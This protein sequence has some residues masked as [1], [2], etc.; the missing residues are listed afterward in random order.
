M[1][2]MLSGPEDPAANSKG[3]RMVLQRQKVLFTKPDEEIE[4]QK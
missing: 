1:I 4:A 3:S 2:L